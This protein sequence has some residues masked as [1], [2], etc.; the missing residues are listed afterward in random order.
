VSFSFNP[1]CCPCVTCDGCS[2]YPL[3]PHDRHKCKVCADYDLCSSC[4]SQRACIH[5]EHDSFDHFS[6]EIPTHG[7]E[8]SVPAAAVPPGV[9]PPAPVSELAT[10]DVKHFYVG[11]EELKPKVIS[12]ALA[13]LLEHPD[14]AVRAATRQAICLAMCAQ[15]AEAA[16]SDAEETAPTSDGDW[17]KPSEEGMTSDTV[18][19]VSDEVAAQEEQEQEEAEAQALEA[20]LVAAKSAK[21][22]D[23]RMT[24]GDSADVVFD[25]VESRGDVTEEFAGIL[26]QYPSVTQAFRIGHLAVHHGAPE[27]SAIAKV[28]VTNDGALPWP[29]LSKLRNVTGPAYSFPE[30]ELG[31][32]PPGD[33]VELVLDFSLG[34]GQP[35][36]SAMSGWA[37]VDEEGQPFGPL[38]LFEVARV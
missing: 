21:V 18:S 9:P 1:A 32:V 6:S 31:P 20:S 34:L 29:E 15:E 11:D 26:S 37:M 27:A 16:E 7:D 2:K 33:A 23:A 5:P 24:F 36:E 38:L 12:S 30:M 13:H 10:E 3:A 28:V 14:E 17:E 19:Q 8:I 4:Y 25:L 22:V 35:G